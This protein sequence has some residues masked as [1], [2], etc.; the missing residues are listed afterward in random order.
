[1]LKVLEKFLQKDNGSSELL[2]FGFHVYA[3][4]TSK[5]Y[6]QEGTV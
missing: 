1:M 4:K 3:R 6:V 2:S 5:I